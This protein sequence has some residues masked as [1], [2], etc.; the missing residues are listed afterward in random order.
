MQRM[1]PMT[2]QPAESLVWVADRIQ[3]F[4][5]TSLENRPK[6]HQT[7]PVSLVNPR[8]HRLGM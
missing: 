4:I 2:D 5:E 6:T 8:Y 3:T 1:A 7:T